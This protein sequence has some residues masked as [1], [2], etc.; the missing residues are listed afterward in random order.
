MRKGSIFL[1]F[2]LIIFSTQLVSATIFQSLSYS[3]G[4]STI[5]LVLLFII[6]L[7]MLKIPLEKM[8]KNRVIATILSFA[9]SLL[10]VHSIYREGFSISNILSNIGIPGG[11]NFIILAIVLIL[12]IYFALKYKLLK[13]RF[14]AIFIGLLLVIIPITN[15][16]FEKGIPIFAGVVL[17]LFGARRIFKHKERDEIIIRPR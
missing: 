11:I 15:N 2:F 13:G 14:L 9:I 3:F 10:I 1:A 5:S 16:W 12:L 6:F 17:I 4:P 8:I 7:V